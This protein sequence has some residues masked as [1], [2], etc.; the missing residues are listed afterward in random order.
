MAKLKVT[1]FALYRWRYVLGYSAIIITLLILLFIA[2]L[3]VPGGLTTAELQTAV[4]SSAI[5]PRDILSLGTINAP[6][7]LLQHASMWLLGVTTF[8]I[9]LPS[10][11]IG[12]ASAIG[13]FLLLRQWFKHN[14][15]VIASAVTLATGHFL[16]VTQDGTPGIMY[17]FWSTYLLLFAMLMAR[18]ARY[19]IVWMFLFFAT[20]ILSLYTPLS[21][22]IL[23]AI[24]SSTILHPH[25]RYIVRRLTG[26]RLVSMA[27]LALVLITPLAYNI[28]RDPS[29]GIHLLGIP[30]QWPNIGHN[31]LQLL[32]Q[33]FDFFSSASGSLM[34]P[35]FSMGSMT[36]ILFG[37]F[38]L[39]R[40]HYTARSYIIA[41]WLLMLLPI[42]LIAPEYTTITFVPL[43][44]LLATGVYTLLHEWYR[45]FPRN[46]YA[47]LIGLLPLTI[48]IAGLFGNGIERYLYGY[49]YNPAVASYFSRDLH[50]IDAEL[51]E[52][53]GNV[54]LVASP[55][56]KSF[57]DAVVHNPKSFSSNVNVTVTTD[58]PTPEEQADAPDQTVIITNQKWH[59][60]ADKAIPTKIIVNAN[61]D[62]ADRLYLYKNN[63]K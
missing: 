37:A 24:A 33:Y 54:T 26:F 32:S 4:T 14:I 20:A 51:K 3:Y 9:K 53:K 55:T 52:L 19:C 31:A 13:M 25:L 49:H 44:L 42:L 27:V 10:L 40:A 47:R 35:I 29:L 56:E 41:V 46:P 5:H 15:A 18:K 63:G 36:L 48:L 11:L 38:H 21:A 43:L 59:E 61:K 60:K 28:Y 16:F 6:Y 23:L 7:L 8:S 1:D 30:T 2:G 45:L 58:T 62:N 57:Y 22:Y 39:I 17:I 12:F 34:T 50:L